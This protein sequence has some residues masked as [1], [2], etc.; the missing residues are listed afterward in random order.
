M[1]I[2][3][4]VL[5]GAILLLSVVILVLGARALKTHQY[6]REIALRLEQELKEQ[7]R[8]RRILTGVASPEEIEQ[9]K[10]K[11]EIPATLPEME[12]AVHEMLL[13]RG[14]VWYGCEPRGVDPATGAARVAVPVPKHQIAPKTLFWV[15]DERPLAQGGAFLGVFEVVGVGGEE[16]QELQ[17]SPVFSL[18][19]SEMD[20]LRRSATGPTRWS[21]YQLVPPDQSQIFA[22]LSP[23]EL[24]QLFP[25]GLFAR[26]EQRDRILAEYAK[27]HKPLTVE[28]AKLGGLRGVVAEMDDRGNVVMENGLPKPLASGKGIFIRQLRDYESLIRW[29]HRQRAEWTDRLAAAQRT[30]NYLQRVMADASVQQQFRQRDVDY[31]RQEK[32]RET[33]ERDLVADHRQTLEQKLESERAEIQRLLTENRRIVAEIAR[34]QFEA[35]Q[36]IEERIREMA[37]AEP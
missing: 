35:I 24:N 21:L 34:A 2:W 4:R 27:D 5:L 1:Y 26:P 13:R 16:N 23:E 36:A 29:F 6:W 32:A 3:N 7:Q 37:L 33:A 31:F 15:F 9:A 10:Q 17:L 11:G 8:L 12:V 18:G 19:P 20:R 25:P 30:S 22:E 14:P 28:E